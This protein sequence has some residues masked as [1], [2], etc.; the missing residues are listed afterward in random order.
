MPLEKAELI[1]INGEAPA[2][3]FMFNPAE[4]AFEGVV[5]TEDNPGARSE[6]SGKPKVSFSN[7]KAYQITINN[8]I[9]D[10][11]ET[12]KDVL[13]THIEPFRKAVRFVEGK[14][15]PP[16]YTFTWGNQVY[17]KRCFVEK[18]SFKLTL[19]LPNGT[20]VRAIIDNL[21]LKEVENLPEDST[22]SP[23]AQPDRGVDTMAGRGG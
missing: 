2:I 15:R 3:P 11:Y 4:L 21:T 20:P 19:F 1:P 6:K 10:T 14:Q 13:K 16:I 8:V 5:E 12:Q 23:P 18:L 9:F 22:S 17:L 7:I